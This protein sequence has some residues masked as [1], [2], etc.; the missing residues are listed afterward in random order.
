MNANDRTSTDPYDANGN[1][2]NS[3]TGANVFDFENR[4]VQSGGVNIVYDGDG[5]RITET[6]ASVTT[7]YLVADQNLTDYAQVMDEL[8]GGVVS[9]TYTYGLDLINQR[10]S[11]SG[12]LSTSFYGYDGHGSVRFLTDST[13]AVTDK[14]DYDAF[15]NLLSQTGTTPNNY[16]F[17]GEQY[18]PAL[19]MYFLRA[20]YYNSTTGRFL[21]MDD[22]EGDPQSPA[23]LHKY[24]MRVRSGRSYRSQRQD[25]S[26]AEFSISVGISA[27]LDAISAAYIHWDAPSGEFWTQV[28]LGFL[29][30]AAIGAI[31]YGLGALVLKL[32][33]PLLKATFEPLFAAVGNLER[34]TLV[35]RRAGKKFWQVESLLPEYQ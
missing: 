35:G 26:I 30:G 3:G 24:C 32:A 28:G 4:L 6:V 25:F 18:D 21:T 29:K 27:T 13:G 15:G 22:Y 20:R 5:N 34:I 12:T 9:R 33:V 10:Q 11:L 1:L 14:Y 2:L 23:S 16:L 19:R 7:R 17:A 8:V 31:G